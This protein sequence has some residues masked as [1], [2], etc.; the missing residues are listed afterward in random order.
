[1]NGD[2]DRGPVRRTKRLIAS[3]VISSIITCPPTPGIGGSGSWCRRTISAAGIVATMSISGAR[4]R[5]G[6]TSSAPIRSWSSRARVG[7]LDRDDV[8]PAQG[9][10]R[11][12][13]VGDLEDATD[14]GHLLGNRPGPLGPGP[15]HLVGALPR[16]DEPPGVRGLERVQAE[17]HRRDDA[18][19]AT[20]AAQRPEE[21]GLAGRVGADHLARGGHEL[22][23]SHRARGEAVAARQPADAAAQRV[24]H[25]ADVGGGAVQGDQAVLGR[26]YR[27][28]FPEHAGA[29]A[30]DARQRVDQHVAQAVGAQQHGIT[31][32]AHGGRVVPGAL[33]RD[34]Q[35]VVAR[36]GQGGGHL[37]GIPGEHHGDRSLV[38]DE[39]PGRPRGVPGLVAGGDD[40]GQALPEGGDGVKGGVSGG[41]HPDPPSRCGV[42][43]TR[44]RGAG[45]P[46]R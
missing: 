13:Q 10:R 40:L 29:D 8:A 5:K 23:R 43:A 26:G 20:A 42:R 21:V 37:A 17:L 46:G 25:H 44:R 18:V 41:R 39:V 1:M 24:A 6:C 38:G 32:L 3:G 15:Q 31:E 2:P 9:L 28:L 12:G 35:P 11:E 4:S 45:R 14:R 16:P 30:G 19:V 22:D 36:D 27:H 7:H 34:P 33:G